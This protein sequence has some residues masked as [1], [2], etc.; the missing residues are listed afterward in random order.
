M[1]LHLDLAT[2]ATVA[3]VRRLLESTGTPSR[4]E[5]YSHLGRKWRQFGFRKR[6]KAGKGLPQAYLHRTA[7]PRR[8]R[9]CG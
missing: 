7:R 2:H 8:R 3:A 5:A 4:S 1:I 6:C 9:P